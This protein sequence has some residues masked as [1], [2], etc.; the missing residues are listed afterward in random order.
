MIEAV[1]ERS[2]GTLAGS[3]NSVPYGVARIASGTGA[4]GA[5]GLVLARLE[6]P[7]QPRVALDPV[8]LHAVPAAIDA[9][10]ALLAPPLALAL[11]MWDRLR[12]ELGELAIVAGDDAFASLV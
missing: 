10:T 8:R 3:A 1:I 9:S 4:D 6:H 11:W 5:T 12:L 7:D 2:S